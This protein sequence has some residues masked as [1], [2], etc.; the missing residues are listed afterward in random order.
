MAK[1]SQHTAVI[2]GLRFVHECPTSDSDLLLGNLKP[3]RN[4]REFQ[5]WLLNG[6]S[7]KRWLVKAPHDHQAGKQYGQGMIR[8][9]I[10]IQ[11]AYHNPDPLEEKQQLELFFTFSFQNQKTGVQSFGEEVHYGCLWLLLLIW[12][13]MMTWNL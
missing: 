2:Y 6:S 9:E 11:K 1:E 8:S 10:F 7:C 4:Y 3:R 5:L 12:R 13:W